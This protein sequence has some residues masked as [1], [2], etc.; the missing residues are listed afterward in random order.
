M[1]TLA[2][3]FGASRLLQMRFGSIN[4]VWAVIL[5]LTPIYFAAGYTIGCRLTSPRVLTE[6]FYGGISCPPSVAA[7]ISDP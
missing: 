6:M 5:G 4:L 3:K 7:S 2:A 1:T